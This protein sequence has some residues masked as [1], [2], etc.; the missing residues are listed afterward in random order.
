MIQNNQNKFNLR[1]VFIDR[2]FTASRILIICSASIGLLIFLPGYTLGLACGLYFVG[3]ILFVFFETYLI[4]EKFF[5]PTFGKRML[6]GLFLGFCLGI[7]PAISTT[8][9]YLAR[10]FLFGGYAIGLKALKLPFTPFTLHTVWRYFVADLIIDFWLL[11][12]SSLTGFITSFMIRRRKTN[13]FDEI[14]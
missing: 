12:F 4:L 8:I 11:I 6:N 3:N 2:E 13:S 14:K 7:I 9:A 1:K 10:D 5:Y